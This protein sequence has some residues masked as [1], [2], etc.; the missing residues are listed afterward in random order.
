MM[1]FHPLLAS[2]GAMVV[3]LL[4][5]VVKLGSAWSRLDIAVLGV[6][7]FCIVAGG[8]IGDALG[9]PAIGWVAGILIGM[10]GAGLIRSRFSRA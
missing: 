9:S 7:I 8:A 3:A 10:T 5:N 4:L 2:V 6:I 1:L